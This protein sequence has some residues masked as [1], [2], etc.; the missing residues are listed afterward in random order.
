MNGQ[1]LYKSGG[2]MTQQRFEI[3]TSVVCLVWDC[4]LCICR[5]C[6]IGA[7]INKLNN[8]YRLRTVSSSY[9]TIR[10]KRDLWN[11]EKF[12]YLSI[13]FTYS[14][15]EISI[16]IFYSNTIINSVIKVSENNTYFTHGK[17]CVFYFLFWLH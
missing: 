3:F 1:I 6:F 14:L 9:I 2:S 8:L 13:N 12:S 7:Q 11:L 5:Y 4:A 15:P 10:K 17:K 16:S